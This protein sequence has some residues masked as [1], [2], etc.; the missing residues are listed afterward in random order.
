[1]AGEFDLPGIRRISA[2]APFKWLRLGWRDLINSPGPC[3]VYGLALALVSLA[4]SLGLFLSGASVWFLIGAGGFVFLAPML[5]MGLY[6]AAQR[7]ESGRKPLLSEMILV[8]AAMRRDLAYLGLALLL[9]Y[10]F[11]G[12]LAQIIYAVSSDRAHRSLQDILVFMLTDPDGQ[13]MTV[14][15]SAVGGVIAFLAFALVVV[16]APM[17]FD[18]RVD[19]FVA[20]FCSVRAVA[21]N[22]S[23]MAVWAV[24]IA[25]LIILSAAT[26]FVALIVVFPWLGLSTWHAYRDVVAAASSPEDRR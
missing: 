24:S 25:L 11:W 16:S 20:T 10:L 14:V 18:R 8:S 6:L 21:T 26:G 7:L 15:G 5:A 2:A 12:R 23:A 13:M 17:L 19:V 22:P 4:I 1:M 9:I 3:L